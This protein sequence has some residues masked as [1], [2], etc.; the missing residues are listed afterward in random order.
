[1]QAIGEKG[2]TYMKKRKVKYTN[3]PIGEIEIVD[4]FLPKPEN[5]VLKEETT[6][7]TLV[8]TKTSIDFFKHEAEKH[9]THYQKMIRALVDQYASHYNKPNKRAGRAH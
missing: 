7:I 4:D 1:M 9:H 2:G 8:L 6:K 5:L 3:E